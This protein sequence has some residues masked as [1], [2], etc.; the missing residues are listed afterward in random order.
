PIGKTSPASVSDVLLEAA[1]TTIQDC[2]DSVAAVDADD[3]A[4]VYGNWLGLMKGDIAATFSKNGRTQHRTLAD[5]RRFTSVDGT[6]VIL[7]GRSLLLVRHVGHLMTTDAVL[8][9]AGRETPEGFLDAMVTTLAS[10]H[11]LRKSAG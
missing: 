3:K 7:P 2:E 10:L 11:D 5:D 8:D 1:L 9:G 4:A 6:P